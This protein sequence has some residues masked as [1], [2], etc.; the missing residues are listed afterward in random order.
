MADEPSG[1]GGGPFASY[2]GRYRRFA[3][4]ELGRQTTEEWWTGKAGQP[5]TYYGSLRYAYD[6]SDELVYSDRTNEAGGVMSSRVRTYDE[7]GRLRSETQPFDQSVRLSYSYDATGARVGT[8]A[9][10]GPGDHHWQLDQREGAPA[11]R[12]AGATGGHTV[13]G[14][15]DGEWYDRRGPSAASLVRVK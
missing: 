10:P 12:G 7:A 9:L 1:E 2:D 13:L 4:D 11:G 8:A 3:F 5:D 14:G 6:S 15:T